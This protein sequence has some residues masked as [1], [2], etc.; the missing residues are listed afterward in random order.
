MQTER[1]YLDLTESLTALL[2]SQRAVKRTPTDPQSW[3]MTVAHDVD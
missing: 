1:C 3:R 2:T